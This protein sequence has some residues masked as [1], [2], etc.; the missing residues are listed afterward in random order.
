VPH[1][2]GPAWIERRAGREQ[3]T[4]SLLGTRPQAGCDGDPVHVGSIQRA[5]TFAIRPCADPVRG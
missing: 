4:G 5:G 2:P 3:L 1:E